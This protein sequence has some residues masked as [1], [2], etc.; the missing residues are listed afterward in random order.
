MLKQ[1]ALTFSQRFE[2]YLLKENKYMDTYI[3]HQN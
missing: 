1:K 2:Y 3:H